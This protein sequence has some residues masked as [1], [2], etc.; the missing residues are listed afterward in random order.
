MDRSDT[1]RER[2]LSLHPKKIDL[3]LDRIHRLLEAMDRP[4]RRLPPLIHIA[5][6]NGKGS[7]TAYLR[8]MLEASGKRVHTYTTPHLVRFHERIRLAELGGSGFVDEETLNAA[9]L[10]AERANGG[11]PITH[12]EI[13]TAAAM[14]IFARVPADILLLEVGLG[15]RLDA[16]NVVSD[17]LACVITPVS[18]DHENYLGDTITEIAGE[19]AGIIKP[20]RPVIVGPQTDEAM[21]VIERAAAAQGAP[22]SVANQDWQAYPERGRLVF[23]DHDGLL[24]LPPPR[25]VGRHQF[26]NAG[27]A[28]ATLRT[29]GLEVP[30]EAIE[31]G[32]Q[33]VEWPARMQ[34]LSAGALVDRWGDRIDE[35]WLDGGHNAGAAVV[36]A[37]VMADLQERAPRPL[38][39][40]VGMVGTKNPTTFLEPLTGLARSLIAVPIADHESHPPDVIAGEARAVGI[41]AETAGSLAEALEI[42]TGTEGARVL[43]CGSLYL[44]GQVLELNETPPQ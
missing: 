26:S 37:E 5:G 11:K 29:I 4:D 6:T 18:I 34:R 19:K 16:T 1:V 35:L 21:D 36:V 31:T 9:L 12:F 23:Q 15:G 32:L 38:V 41:P 14:A 33:T 42:A 43:I 2:L 8:A 44:A 24:D 39:L 30:I 20:G 22:L 40:I 28:I 7:T 25:L 10:E 27:I 13:T 3:S 17:P